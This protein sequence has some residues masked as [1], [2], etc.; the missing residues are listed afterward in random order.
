[1]FQRAITLLT[2]ASISAGC[3][4]DTGINALEA[5]IAVSPDSVEFGEIIVD[6]S[7]AATVEVISTGRAPL[8]V[9]GISWESG[10]GGVLSHDGGSFELTR[11]ERLELTI[12][13]EPS[14]YLDYSDNLLIASDDPDRPVLEVPVTCTGTHAPTPHINID[15]MTLDFSTLEVGETSTQWAVITNTGDGD[16]HIPETIQDGGGVFTILMDPEGATISADETDG[17][18]V[19]V[20]YSPTH[21]EG[22]WGTLIIESDDPDAIDTDG[23]GYGETT[24]N[25]LG[26]CADDCEYEYPVAVIEGV[27]AADPLDTVT[28][29]GSASYDPYGYDLTYAWTI[30]SAPDGSSTELTSSS[31]SYTDLFLDLAGTYE[32]QLVVTN[33]IGVASAPAKHTIEVIPEDAVHIELVWDSG[34]SDFDLHLI[35]DGG[36][37]FKDPD[38]CN[39]CNTNPDWGVAGDSSDDPRL[40]LD[41]R[42]GWGPENIN[43][44]APANGDYEIRVHYFEDYGSDATTATVKVWLDGALH[45][46][47][48][49]VMERDEVWKVGW[50]NWPEATLGES[51]EAPTDSN[52]RD[53]Y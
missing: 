28:L 25:L 41:D 2:I 38:D 50:V 16:L 13:C 35:D 44:E 10:T 27:E 42:S 4:P 46:E 9:S 20:T 18:V 40:D 53:C 23:D 11:D 39:F 31:G 19:V 45:W 49:E 52:K 12:G 8:T 48:S 29:D 14:T 5:V 30:A 22:D 43:I 24:L 15:P 7:D 21:G 36:T 34:S 3:T 33:E 51:G 17:F 1:M 26:N 32:V 6:Y 37:Y 47:G